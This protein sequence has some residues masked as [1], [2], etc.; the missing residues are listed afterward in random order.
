ME[1]FIRSDILIDV[2]RFELRIAEEKRIMY[3]QKKMKQMECYFNG[4]ISAIIDIM[5]HYGIKRE[6]E[7]HEASNQQT[8]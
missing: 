3:H 7:K 5:S 8:L 1:R 2:L 4:R 6:E